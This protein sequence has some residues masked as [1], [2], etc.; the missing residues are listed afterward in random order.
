[1]GL[2]WEAYLHLQVF[3][4]VEHFLGKNGIRLREPKQDL[5]LIGLSKLLLELHMVHIPTQSVDEESYH[6]E[7]I[8]FIYCS[9]NS[10]S[11]ILS[12]FQT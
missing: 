7:K 9:R 11:F 3:V 5:K 2:F 4:L 10:G 1:M 8:I 6:E 12:S